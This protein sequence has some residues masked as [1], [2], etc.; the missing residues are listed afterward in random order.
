MNFVF[1]LNLRPATRS[2][3]PIARFG[4]LA[5]IGARPINVRF[6]PESGHGGAMAGCPLSADFV[7]KVAGILADRQKRA[8]L[9][10][11][12]PNF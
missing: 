10:S 2:L 12:R 9:E 11:E 7:A 4:S 3:I 1:E 8:I 6:A 5:D